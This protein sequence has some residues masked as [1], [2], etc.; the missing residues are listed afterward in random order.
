MDSSTIG[1]LDEYYTELLEGINSGGTQLPSSA[2]KS[3]PIPFTNDPNTIPTHI[4]EPQKRVEPSFQQTYYNE[5]QHQPTQHQPTQHQTQHQPYKKSLLDY[6]LSYLKTPILLCFCY[7]IFQMPIIKSCLMLFLPSFFIT[8]DTINIYGLII[9]SILFAT[10][11][12]GL[13]QIIKRLEDV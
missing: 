3:D 1:Q 12:M 4:M 11:F 9:V 8:N 7:F 6:F 5:Q 10:G 13:E 2:I